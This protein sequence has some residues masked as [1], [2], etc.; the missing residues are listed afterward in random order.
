[1]TSFLTLLFGFLL[2]PVVAGLLAS[3]LCS[4]SILRDEKPPWS[5]AI[6]S[7]TLGMFCSLWFLFG[8]DVFHPARWPGRIPGRWNSFVMALGPTF[9][10]TIVVVLIAVA[11]FRERLKK[12]LSMEQ[13][14]ALSRQRHQR[15]WQRVRWFHLL[16]SSTLM[17]GLTSAL[18][19]SHSAR[20]HFEDTAVVSDYQAAQNWNPQSPPKP[21][22]QVGAGRRT[23][24]FNL[25]PVTVLY[26]PVCILG[27]VASGGWFAY[28][29]AYWRGYMRV[30]P[31]HRRDL[32]VWHHPPA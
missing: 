26:W 15:A 32:L 12:H 18:V 3:V 8:A 22:R 1:V 17:V 19:W 24:A 4:L 13:R 11:L 7:A 30:K 31:R 25:A 28:T 29:V 23:P 16:A 9:S 6:L 2:A 10:F 5:H 14:R 27:L 21:E 20:A